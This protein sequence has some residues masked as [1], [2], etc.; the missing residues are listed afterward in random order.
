[1]HGAILALLVVM[2]GQSDPVRLS[3]GL[4]SPRFADREAAERALGELGRVAIPALRVAETSHDPEIRVRASALLQKIEGGLLVEPTL[5]NLDFDQVSLPTA[6]QA[7]NAQSGLHLKLLP[8]LPQIWADRKL[9]IHSPHP[10]PFWKALD[11][12]CEAGQLHFVFGGQ[13]DFDQGEPS[14]A[15]YDGFAANAGLFDEH[16]P[17]RVQV[18]SLHYQSEVHLAGDP[19]AAPGL[20]PNGT[21]PAVTPRQPN[22]ATRQFFAQMLVGAEPR[23]S[24]APGGPIKVTEAIDDR[25]QSL[26]IPATGELIQ[27]ESGYLGVNSSPLV[28]L[29][30]DMTYPSGGSKRLKKVKG[31]VPLVVSTRKSDP[32]EIPLD[33]STDKTFR[34]SGVVITVGEI[35]LNQPDQPPTIEL[36]IKSSRITGAD[37]TGDDMDGA[38]RSVASPQ[39]LEVLD[40]TGKMIP[41]FPSSSFFN[42]EES[43]LS[44]TLLDRG[45]PAVP[46]TIRYYSVI[47]DRTEVPFEFRDLPM[48]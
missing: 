27:H 12:I 3:A 17:F 19:Q 38:I 1:M 29:R 42:G 48:P 40:A 23:L 5:V 26:V 44:L 7:I 14:F 39:Q 10:L 35:K 31:L 21:L 32:L 6:I 46:T 18:A 33:N 9:T 34:Q 20:F 43:R 25:G 2:G 16:G 28:H 37:P 15:L 24:I 22:L 36:T 13:A 8:E 41:W 47:R 11:A 45:G 30:L 4:G